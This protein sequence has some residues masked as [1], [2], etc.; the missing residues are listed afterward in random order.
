MTTGESTYRTVL[1]RVVFP[2]TAMI[3]L[4]SIDRVNISFAALRMNADIGLD[5]AAYGLGASLFF[6]GYIACQLP[7][8]AVLRRIGARRWIAFSVIGWGVTAALMGLVT[9]RTQFFGLRVL[10]GVFESGFAPG[11]V[12]YISQW[13]PRAY[14]ARSLSLSMVAIPLSVVIGG[15]ICGALVS[16]GSSTLPGWRLMFFVEGAVTVLAGF[17]ALAWFVDRPDQAKWLDADQRRWIA[18]AAEAETAAGGGAEAPPFSR[19]IRTPRLWVCAF[20][21]FVLVTASNAMVFWLPLTIKAAGQH[22]PLVIGV[23][24]ALPWAALG[25]GLLL[26]ARH[27]DRTG[28]R[29]WH[30]GIAAV[31]GASGL[32]LAAFAGPSAAALALLVV[33]CFGIG[34]AQSVFW[35]IPTE[36]PLTR[37]AQAIVTINLV[38][39]LS[40]L[41]VPAAIGRVVA[42]TGS[43]AMPIYALA[44]LTL[45]AVPLL[46]ILGRGSV[47][48]AV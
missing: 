47:R 44:A 1:W 36:S 46:A 10:L 48:P 13:L 16:L 20:L 43:T 18:E 26:N 32:A 8:A 37:H 42:A 31:L 5:P 9:N 24:S 23:L 15:P 17:A 40:G 34:G 4:S 28:E 21:W 19:L 29:R 6:V 41:I 14:R 27:S 2:I 3:V 25:T 33:G 22:D 45:C 38:G 39:N 7:S 35:A 12:W 30:V 11:T